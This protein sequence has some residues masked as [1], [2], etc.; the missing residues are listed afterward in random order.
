MMAR[1]DPSCA[2]LASRMSAMVFLA[3][4]HRGSEYATYLSNTPRR[5]EIKETDERDHSFGIQFMFANGNEFQLLLPES[6]D[7]EFDERDRVM[8]STALSDP[9]TEIPV[10]LP[11]M[12]KP[13]SHL[14]TGQ[15]QYIHQGGT[16]QNRKCVHAD[17]IDSISRQI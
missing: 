1:Q 9:E 14:V 2:A 11:S 15:I 7:Y 13:H 16:D 10:H 3:T 5:V 17:N 6:R 8:K 4:P 12:L